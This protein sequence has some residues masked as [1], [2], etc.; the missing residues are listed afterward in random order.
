MKYDSNF[1]LC[2]N[3]QELPEFVEIVAEHVWESNTG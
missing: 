3:V 2:V 1:Y